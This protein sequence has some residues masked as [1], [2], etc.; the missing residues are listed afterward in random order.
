MH[1]PGDK[2]KAYEAYDRLV[3]ARDNLIGRDMDLAIIQAVDY[4][5]NNLRAYLQYFDNMEDGGLDQFIRAVVDSEVPDY[6]GRML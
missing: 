6:E 4:Q 3:I 2:A 1:Q 5:I